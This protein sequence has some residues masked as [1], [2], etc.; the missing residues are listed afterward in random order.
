[1]GPRL[2]YVA[3]SFSGQQSGGVDMAALTTA[4]EYAAVREAIQLL[5]TLNT[6]GTRRDIVSVTSPG[7][8]SVTYAAS[9]MDFLQKRELELARRLTIR[10]TRKRTFPEFY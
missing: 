1:V 3:F 7:G 8:M 6:D 10:N 9:Q 4:Q 2:Y 5:T